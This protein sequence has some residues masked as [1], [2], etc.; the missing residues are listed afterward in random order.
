MREK[1]IDGRLKISYV[2]KPDYNEKIYINVYF[3]RKH[4]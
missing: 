4:V 2:L 3:G 1:G